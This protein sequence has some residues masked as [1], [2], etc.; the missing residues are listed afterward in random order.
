[1]P[2]AGPFSCTNTPP[3]RV[4][5]RWP[6]GGASWARAPVSRIDA[7]RR[8]EV[9]RRITDRSRTNK[10]LP[11]QRRMFATTRPRKID[12]SKRGTE[13][14]RVLGQR[15]LLATENTRHDQRPVNTRRKYNLLSRRRPQAM[16]GIAH[17]MVMHFRQIVRRIETEILDVEPANRAEQ[18]IGGDHAV[19][20]RADQASL[21]Q[22]Q[23]LLRVQDI[24][25]GTLAAGGLPLHALQGDGGGTDFGFGGG[26]GNLGAFIGDPGA[27]RGG[28]GL[29]ANLIQYLSALCRDFLGLPGLRGRHAAVIDRLGELGGHRGLVGP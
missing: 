17:L 20:L 5:T 7:A 28:A 23:I 16:P 26:D 2:S 1:M 12:R 15:G 6:L 22:N 14:D 8:N 29:A 9:I 11:D 25:G 21:G 27:D 19:A 24:E 18:G 10:P 13:T 4:G 3:E